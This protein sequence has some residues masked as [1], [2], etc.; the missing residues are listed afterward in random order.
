MYIVRF[1]LSGLSPFMA[2]CWLL[3][4]TGDLLQT[5]LV[6]ETSNV[7]TGKMEIRETKTCALRKNEEEP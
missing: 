3:L 1:D 7:V 5:I 4:I 2:L 6:S